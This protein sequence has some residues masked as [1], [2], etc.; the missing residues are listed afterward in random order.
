MI[1]VE[2]M[3]KI[4]ILGDGRLSTEIRNQVKWP[5]ISRKQNNFDFCD[6]TTL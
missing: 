5:Y 2:K 6:L 3:A 1:G 4:L